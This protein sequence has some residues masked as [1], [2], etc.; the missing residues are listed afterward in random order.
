LR[1]SEKAQ[2]V[3]EFLVA[4]GY[5]SRWC[6]RP[7]TDRLLLHPEGRV[8]RGAC[9][10]PGAGQRQFHAVRIKGVE[11]KPPGTAVSAAGVPNSINS[12]GTLSLHPIAAEIVNLHNR[13][14]N[15]MSLAILING[16]PLTFKQEIIIDDQRAAN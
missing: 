13:I 4:V 5:P 2:S 8:G 15:A 16:Q 6:D 3:F 7:G 9:Y 10:H 1:K 12:I 11:P 14:A